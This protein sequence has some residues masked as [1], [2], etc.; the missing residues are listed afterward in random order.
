MEQSSNEITAAAVKALL[1]ATVLELSLL[2]TEDNAARIED[3][4]QEAAIQ[5]ITLAGFDA[6]DSDHFGAEMSDI[7]QSLLQ[8]VMI[9]CPQLADRLTG[10]DSDGEIALWPR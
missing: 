5:L 6:Q 7:V 9:R 10:V 4:A 2:D 8:I 3:G 1:N